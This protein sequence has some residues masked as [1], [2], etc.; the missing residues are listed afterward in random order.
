M[1]KRLI[2]VNNYLWGDIMTV[3]YKR[4][5]VVLFGFLLVANLLFVNAYREN[6]LGGEIISSECQVVKTALPF[7]IVK[8][9]LSL[10]V[11]RVEEFSSYTTYYCHSPY[12]NIFVKDSTGRINCQVSVKNETTT[13]G[14]PIITTGYWHSSN[15]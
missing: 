11:F 5:V 3:I 15:S 9:Q 14:F 10:T 13:V 1:N 4:L 7:N 2:F 6:C 8:E 12:F